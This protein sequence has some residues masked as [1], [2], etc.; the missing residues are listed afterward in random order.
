M[1]PIYKKKYVHE[2]NKTINLIE[3]I[4]N[5]CKICTELRKY[6]KIYTPCTISDEKF[7]GNYIFHKLL[8]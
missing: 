1:T 3:I 4:D 7:F 5:S 6:L 8:R 2:C